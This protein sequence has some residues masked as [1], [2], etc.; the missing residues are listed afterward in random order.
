M[1]VLQFKFCL[2]FVSHNSLNWILEVPSEQEIKIL[3]KTGLES[4]MTIR[5]TKV[6]M[7][8]QRK[9]MHLEK[10]FPYEPHSHI[11][12]LNVVVFYVH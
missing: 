1:N 12:H 4:L 3:L 11:S 6:A 5:A 8:Q 9:K 10:M 7:L 2:V